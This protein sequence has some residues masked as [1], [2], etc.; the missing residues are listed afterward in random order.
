M[1]F[2]SKEQQYI[3]SLFNLHKLLKPSDTSDLI[4]WKEITVRMGIHLQTDIYNWRSMWASTYSAFPHT[5]VL[6]AVFSY[7]IDVNKVIMGSDSQEVTVCRH[8]VKLAENQW[9]EIWNF[10]WTLT[11]YGSVSARWADD[12]LPG[13]YLTLEM[14]SLPSVCIETRSRVSVSS[15]NHLQHTRQRFGKMH[16]TRIQIGRL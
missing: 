4:L 2:S 13:E 7:S 16:M 9:T 8:K 1:K 11:F 5:A 6:S 14:I 10:V 15:T 12:V 3:N